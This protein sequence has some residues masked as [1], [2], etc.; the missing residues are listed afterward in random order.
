M[1]ITNK[2]TRTAALCAAL[3]GLLFV[4]VQ[5]AHPALDL[6]LVTTTEW[7]VRQSMKVLMAVLSLVGITGIYLRHSTEM[8]KVG[9]L[10]YVVFASGFLIVMSVE[11]IALCVLPSIATTSP[12]FVSDVLALA[13]GGSVSGD[14][15]WYKTL[16][17]VGGLAYLGGGLIFGIAILRARTLARWAAALLSLGALSTVLIGVLPD[18]N[19]RVFAVP[20]GL[21]LIG[22]GYSLWR[23]EVRHTRAGASGS[24]SSQ[25][26]PD[27]HQATLTGA[28]AA[29][30]HLGS[31]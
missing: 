18:L 12:A 14:V 16:T 6:A 17:Q 23:Q 10:G 3:G 15:G 21:A 29:P 8:G 1:T 22:L 28:S 25:L 7:K 26:D 31:A 9:T 30:A 5:I 2:L 4:T 27:G 20:T 24:P 11:L 13:D 19:P